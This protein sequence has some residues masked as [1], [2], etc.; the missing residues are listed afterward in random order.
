MPLPTPSPAALPR[1]PVVPTVAGARPELTVGRRTVVTLDANDSRTGALRSWKQAAQRTGEIETLLAQAD[2][3]GATTGDAAL[4]AIQ[5][6]SV[7][8]K[9]SVRDSQALLEF[10]QKTVTGVITGV[11]SM[12]EMDYV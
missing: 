9:L 11:F 3:A 4:A 12:L 10:N 8:K 6:E 5:L 1:L 2:S 7:T